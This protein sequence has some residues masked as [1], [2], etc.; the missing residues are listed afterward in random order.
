M[1]VSKRELKQSLKK[2]VCSTKSGAYIFL[3]FDYKKKIHKIDIRR[4]VIPYIGTKHLILPSRTRSSTHK[5]PPE[6]L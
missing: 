3:Q 5:A 1:A 6:E 2:V 4:K